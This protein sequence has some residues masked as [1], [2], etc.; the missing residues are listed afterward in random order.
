MKARERFFATVDRPLSWTR[1]IIGGLALWIV[2]IIL[3]G[4]VPSWLIYQ[5]DAKV[6]TLIDISKHI[7]GVG[8]AGMNPTQIRILRDIVANGV[9]FTFLGIILFSCYFWQKAKRRRLN[10]PEGP[11]RTRELELE[12]TARKAG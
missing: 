7:P 8:S 10:Q 12:M 1:A 4:Q 2:I 3:L 9:Q 11:D 5:A 6:S